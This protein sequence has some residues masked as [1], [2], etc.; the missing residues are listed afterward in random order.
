VSGGSY[1]YLF[2]KDVSQLMQYGPRE[3]LTRMRDRLVALPYAQDAASETEELILIM[4][5]FETRM[6]VRMD[7]LRGVWKAVEWR[8]SGDSDDDDVKVALLEYRCDLFIEYDRKASI[9]QPRTADEPH[10]TG[11]YNVYQRNGSRR[12]LVAGPVKKPAA[13]AML[14]AASGSGLGEP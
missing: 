4:Q 1:D 14:E 3:D 6:K 2:V 13:I 5:Q 7:R 10:P 9:A 8:D 11:L 12:E